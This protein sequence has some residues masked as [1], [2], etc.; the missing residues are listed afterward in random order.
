[1]SSP[2]HPRAAARLIACVS[3][4]T[5]AVPAE[6][7]QVAQAER[8]VR[9]VVS[10]ANV[11]SG[12]STTSK[13]LFRLAQGE[14]ARLLETQGSWHRIEDTAG[15][16][17]YVFKTTVEVEERPAAAAADVP[18][19]PPPAPVSLDVEHQRV[20]CVVAEQFPRIEACLVPEESVG[21][22]SV[23]F[24]AQADEPW[25][26][27]ELT[28]DGPCHSAYLPKP[29]SSTREIQYYVDVVDRALNTRQHPAEAPAGAYRARVVTKEGEC[30]ALGRMARGVA[31][32]GRPIVVHIA[33]DAAGVVLDASAAQALEAKALL[34]GFRPESVTIASTGA[35]P[36]E[37]SAAGAGGGAAFAGIGLGTLAIAGGAVIAGGVLLAASGGD[38]G[39]SNG[40]GGGGSD[41]LN[42]RWEGSF[43]ERLTSP[44]CGPGSATSR[45]TM[46]I[47]QSGSSFTGTSRVLSSSSSI[48]GV[49]SS[50]GEQAGPRVT[51]TAQG[52]QLQISFPAANGG[53]GFCAAFTLTGSY[54]AT[55]INAS[56][57]YSCSVL[58]SSVTLSL[59]KQ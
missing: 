21:R 10:S 40:G 22:A 24:R 29:M 35:G 38:D 49:N 45:V 33:R 18:A 30:G 8:R 23:H 7:L 42:G 13:V 25:Y 57:S 16:T 11:R 46:D 39:G 9:V 34:A 44:G 31:R 36:A 37:G 17:G 1:M 4:L 3:A 27:V 51:G 20:G 52:G 41:T 14:T 26:A 58:S 59:S 56:G 53:P 5:L 6:A 28:R 15:R 48:C 54:S 2:P 19:A 43:M 47:T 12:P 32:A 50:S 55:S